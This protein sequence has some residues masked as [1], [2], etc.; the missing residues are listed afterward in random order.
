MSRSLGSPL[1][2]VVVRAAP[3]MPVADSLATAILAELP[4]CVLVVVDVAER[5]VLLAARPSQRV[6]AAPGDVLR[7]AAE[8]YES[9]LRGNG[10]LASRTDRSVA[11]GSPLLE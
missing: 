6:V 10:M 7:T 4:G 5:G 11:L 9:L 2:D 1:A 3:C 8:A